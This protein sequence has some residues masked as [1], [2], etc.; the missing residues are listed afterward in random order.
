MAAA[1]V[2]VVMELAETGQVAQVE[3]A[4]VAMIQELMPHPERQIQAAAAEA[5]D[6]LTAPTTVGVA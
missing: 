4:Q 3:A 5:M 2:V 6:S 1:A